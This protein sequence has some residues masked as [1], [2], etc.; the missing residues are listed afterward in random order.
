MW[1]YSGMTWY[2]H[3]ISHPFLNLTRRKRCRI[4]SYDYEN[5]A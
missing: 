5:E 3:T 4:K 2:L 1:G